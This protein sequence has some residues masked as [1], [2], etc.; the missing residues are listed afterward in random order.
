MLADQRLVLDTDEKQ[1]LAQRIAAII[2]SRLDEADATDLS[3]LAW[4]Q[5]H[6]QNIEKAIEYTRCGLEIDPDN[7][8]CLSLAHRLPRL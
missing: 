2:E 6:L 5:M 4:L 7:P 8:H 3:R 1:I